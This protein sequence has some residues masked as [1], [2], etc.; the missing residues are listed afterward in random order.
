MSNNDKQLEAGKMLD[1][2]ASKEFPA[3]YDLWPTLKAK[4]QLPTAYP[5]VSVPVPKRRKVSHLRVAV[6]SGLL[7][8]T[9]LTFLV[10]I[11]LIFLNPPNGEQGQLGVPPVTPVIG[12]AP[13]AT[14]TPLVEVTPKPTETVAAP[15][16]AT[17]QPTVLPKVA[18]NRLRLQRPASLAWS[19]DGSV[20]A[21]VGNRDED[22]VRLWNRAGKLTKV[23]PGFGIEVRELVWS[24]DGKYL[25]VAYINMSKMEVKIWQNESVV[26]TIPQATSPMWSPDSLRLVAASI[27][28]KKVGVWDVLGKELFTVETS[29][30][31]AP[32]RPIW[33]P[34]GSLIAVSQTEPG[35]VYLWNGTS[36]KLVGQLNDTSGWL[37][38]T[39]DSQTLAVGNGLTGKLSLFNREGKL[40]RTIIEKG[41]PINMLEWSPD[42]KILALAVGGSDTTSVR[43]WKPDGTLL[44]T[45]SGV[46]G[47]VVYLD[48]SPDSQTLVT[49][50]DDTPPVRFWS[51][52]GKLIRSG[53][54]STQGGT[55]VAWS[56]DGT[57]LA[58]HGNRGSGEP[59]IALWDAGGKQ[60]LT[61]KDATVR[62][63]I[64]PDSTKQDLYG[65][66]GQQ[67]LE[68]PTPTPLVTKMAATNSAGTKLIWPVRGTITTYFGQKMWTSESLGITINAA[69][70][71][72]IVAA[73]SGKVISAGYDTALGN[74]LNISHSSGLTTLYAHLSK[75][76]VKAGQNVNQGQRVGLLGCSGHTI[77]P[78]LG[79]QIRR[80][81]VDGAPVN[82]LDYLPALP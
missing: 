30:K 78:I 48:W 74:Y 32:G 62:S 52:E 11:S 3:D 57:L 34:D 13:D 79:F 64:T 16:A 43:L 36:G 44:A 54:L 76:E 23:L 2:W 47:I 41:T 5:P 9:I 50:V 68:L 70:G 56:P 61:L 60:L 53:G 51:T 20:L 63:S 1:E 6:L 18:K 37:D 82:P 27:S 65:C 73:D 35:T 42:D 12:T 49:G 26:A 58:S 15:T 80:G 75:L 69:P 14:A 25:A 55:Q 46:D 28:Q 17:A 77:G 71:T 81:G 67:V 39:S 10:G 19:P 4:A 72:P 8:T 22:V 24:P 33:S 40:I 29:F 45:L 59:E 66:N 21:T 7:L 31:E 38:W